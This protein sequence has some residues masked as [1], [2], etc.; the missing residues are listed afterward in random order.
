MK[1]GNDYHFRF[2]TLLSR[3]GGVCALILAGLAWAGAA[4][5]GT[6]TVTVADDGVSNI[7]APGTFYW[8]ITNCGPGDTIAFNIPGSGPHYLQI[9]P[10]GFPLVYRK[11]NL[12]IDGYT[13][14]G[15]SPNTHSITQAN[16]A[17]INIV[18]DGRNGNARDMHYTG[19]GTTTPVV[20][21]IDNSSM[22]N[23]QAGYGDTELAHLGV[24]RSTNVTVRGL[25]FLGTFNAT[26]GDQKGIC[27]AHDYGY[28]TNVL[29][30]LDY[31]EGSDAN[32]HVC[33]CWFGVDPA[34]PTMP[35]VAGFLI[36]IAH[37]RHQDVSNGPR[38]DL[39]NVG[40]TVG[41]AKGSTNPVAEFN[42]FA[43]LGY[44]MDGENIR[45][46][47]SGNFFGVLPDG[48][49][50]YNMPDIDPTDF[51]IA[52]NGHFEWGRFDDT[53]PMIIGTDGDG[54]N[55]A[56]EGNLF[57]PLDLVNGSQANIFDF[58]DTGRKP[59]IIAG[60][61]FG[62]GV[63]GTVWEPN[64]FAIFGGLSLDQGTQVR[65]GS[66]FNGVSDDLEAN[67]VCDNTPFSTLYA[68]PVGLTAPS[69]F[70]GMDSS[71]VTPDAWV[72]VRGNVL[73]NNF[74]AFD[75][76]DPGAS[77][78]LNWWANYLAYTVPSPE[79]TNAIP[80][81]AASS[82]V[83]LLAGTFGPTTT[84][85]YT[86]LVLDLYLPDPQGQTNGA[87]FDQPSF[88]GSSGWGFVQGKTYLGSCVIPD[89]A[90]GAFALDISGLGLAAGT[91]VTAALTYSS[92]A[93]PYITKIS[94]AGTNT[95]LAW[96]GDNGG[97]FISAGA[98]GPSCGFGIQR[99]ES[100]SGPWTTSF[101][102]SNSIVLTDTGNTAFYRI[103]GPVSGMTTLCA[104]PVALQSG[105]PPPDVAPRRGSNA[106]R[107]ADARLR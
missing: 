37:Y 101:A 12:L 39:P 99:A 96:T 58:Y 28:N 59:Y 52:G 42:V 45:S 57:G 36:G 78:F 46:R 54:V 1:T 2:S 80:T 97:P 55:D 73:V 40:L 51:A 3:W 63:D 103:I 106:R 90:S 50:P 91:K 72:S 35:S 60:N 14:P 65:F 64:S 98:G 70:Q 17:V 93:R 6:V 43:G 100:L 49:T 23:E 62:I 92:F 69:L 22:Q 85:G 24:Y 10:G 82:T 61:R 19:Y 21:A 67:I 18:I 48:V 16:N 13:Q 86:N 107:A 87:Q 66:D 104:P 102:A 4:G 15:A 89:P 27:F 75:P 41:V 83:S 8:A 44:A 81:L 95:T 53:E 76:D 29:D 56:E 25:A 20:P 88:G 31:A 33:G 5:A 105:V 11:P 34:R 77:N 26:G 84:N 32:G 68:N 30:R 74:P 38:P 79:P 9:P 47:A 94:H 7:G 71:N